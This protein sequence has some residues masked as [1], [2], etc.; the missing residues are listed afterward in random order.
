MELSDH[1]R[2]IARNWWRIVIIAVLAA[3]LVYAWSSD[4]QERFESSTALNVTPGGAATSDGTQAQSVFLARTY[5]QLADT[6]PVLQRAVAGAVPLTA[7]QAQG[8]VHASA[9]QDVGFITIT[10]SGDTPRL[11]QRLA[12][13]VSQALVATVAEQQVRTLEQ[14]LQSVNAEITSLAAQLDALPPNAPTRSA[15]QARYEALLQSQTARRAAP[16]D[17]VEVVSP[18]RLPSSPVSP[19]PTRDAMLAFV[20]ALIVVS[21]SFVLYRVLTQRFSSWNLQEVSRLTGLPVLATVPRGG[22]ADVVEAVRS[23]R[24]NLYVLP[25]SETPYSTAIVSAG[26]GAGKSFISAHLAASLAGQGSRVM[27]IDADLRRPVLHKRFGIARR[28]GLTDALDGA[29]ITET[30]YTVPVPAKH[31]VGEDR[32]FSLMPSGDEVPDPM[33]LFGTDAF[34]RVLDKRPF[35]ERFT[36]IDTPPIDL[37]GDAIAIAAQSDSVIVVVDMK[38]SRRGA[39]I[40]AVERLQRSGATILGLVIN[41]APSPRNRRYYRHRR[42]GSHSASKTSRS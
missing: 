32:S 33:A 22:G 2:V 13:A 29:D 21:E 35:F 23:L 28:P 40:D 30:V 16:Q 31:A 24:G 36:I 10:A 5:A 12:T 39:V 6:I 42:S 25:E 18:A 41:G 19:R 7:A 8:D 26:Q 37:F 27:L 3:G 38:T 15:L 1:A 9:S 11:A 4:R 20:V 34:A 14:D 17:R